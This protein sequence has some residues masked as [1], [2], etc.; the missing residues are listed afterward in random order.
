MLEFTDLHTDLTQNLGAERQNSI[1]QSPPAKVIFIK[2]N[3]G[4]ILLSVLPPL[5]YQ[6]PTGL[7]LLPN[8]DV[9]STVLTKVSSEIEG[10]RYALQLLIVAC[11]MH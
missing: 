1:S 2:A 9:D 6:S 10:L 11:N 8:N 5:R 7:H 3:A 4:L